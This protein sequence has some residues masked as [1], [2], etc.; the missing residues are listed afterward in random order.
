M[1]LTNSCMLLETV[2]CFCANEWAGPL[3]PSARSRCRQSETHPSGRSSRVRAWCGEGRPV[4]RQLRRRCHS[5]RDLRPASPKRETNPR[6]MYRA[7]KKKREKGNCNRTRRRRT[8][9]QVAT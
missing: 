3:R 2:L 7:E 9:G 4:A 1:S 8:V 5:L 6:E